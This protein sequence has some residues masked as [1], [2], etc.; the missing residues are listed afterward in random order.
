MIARRQV[1][2]IRC[3]ECGDPVTDTYCTEFERGRI[4]CENCTQDLKRQLDKLKMELCVIEHLQDT[5]IEWND[6]KNVVGLPG[7]HIEVKFVE[8][9]NVLDA[10]DQ[11]KRDA[12]D[13]EIPTVWHKKNHGPLLVTL[14]ADDFMRIYGDAQ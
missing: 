13:G 10:Y 3:M 6:D 14:H 9:L 5:E 2:Y 7:V 1:E 12:R 8:K 4:L 11:S